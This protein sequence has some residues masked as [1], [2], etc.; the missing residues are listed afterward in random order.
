M[1]PKRNFPPSNPPLSL[2]E[3]FRQ[4]KL[5]YVSHE[6]VMIREQM[7]GQAAL[8]NLVNFGTAPEQLID[9]LSKETE[10]HK[11]AIATLN[12]YATQVALGNA[13][14]WHRGEVPRTAHARFAGQ[15]PHWHQDV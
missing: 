12:I 15:S 5:K 6:L 2:L 14:L 4:R 8:I 7:I 9:A 11:D 10:A 1:P 3:C 13:V